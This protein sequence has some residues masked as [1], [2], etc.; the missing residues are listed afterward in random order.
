MSNLY[1]VALLISRAT[2]N[3]ESLEATPVGTQDACNRL[4]SLSQVVN[5]EAPPPGYELKL[6]CGSEEALET[7]LT[8]NRCSVI[9]QEDRSGFVTSTYTCQPPPP[10]WTARLANWA[11][12]FLN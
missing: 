2:G 7:V 4:G 10:G 1:F 9:G 11:S 5:A 8:Q 6:H 3:V 12:S